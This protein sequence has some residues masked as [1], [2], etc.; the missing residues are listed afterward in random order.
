MKIRREPDRLTDQELEI[1]K[2]VWDRGTASV[3]DVYENLLKHRKVAYT[4]V[5]TMM[6]ILETKGFLDKSAGDRAYLYTP[7]RPRQQV[8]GG[9]IR[10]FVQR[11][12]NGSA[13]PLL[14]QLVEE[15]RLSKRD[16]KQ[17]AKLLKERK[18]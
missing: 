16:L 18:R 8:I 11:V 13:E 2:I 1:M 7:T 15:D 10:D 17:I 6:N 12:L 9:M 4:T 14:L 3:R 5:M